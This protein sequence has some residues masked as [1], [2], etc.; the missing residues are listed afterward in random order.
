MLKILT[1]HML[2]YFLLAC[3]GSVQAQR[4]ETTAQLPDDQIIW[5]LPKIELGNKTVVVQGFWVS[6]REVL[7]VKQG[8]WESIYR[9]YDYRVTAVTQGR[10]APQHLIFL[11]KDREP[12]P[13]SGIFLK[14]VPV[15]FKLGAMQFIVEPT[16]GRANY[17][18][19]IA[20]Q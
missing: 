20:Y 14:R 2:C 5:P 18:Q 4:L 7:R 6:T 12:T 10:F 16:D 8:D 3:A 19:I 13:E 17:Y 11:L 15:P 1:H 9:L